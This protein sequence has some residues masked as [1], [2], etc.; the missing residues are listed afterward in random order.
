MTS[1]RPNENVRRCPTQMDHEHG[2]DNDGSS[3]LSD[4]NN[5]RHSSTPFQYSRL[6]GPLSG[7]GDPMTRSRTKKMQD[8]LNTLIE[9]V[10]V[11]GSTIKASEISKAIHLLSIV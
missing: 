10:H 7:I 8:A 1:L 5:L 2:V 11:E 3:S 9:E 4:S 6:N